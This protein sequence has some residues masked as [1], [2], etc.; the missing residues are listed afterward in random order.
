[1]S[2]ILEALKKADSERKKSGVSAHS[3]LNIAYAMPVEKKKSK[4]W[5]WLIALNMA[6]LVSIF[7]VSIYLYQLYSVNSSA[8]MRSK[9]TNN[10]TAINE[11]AI[12]S[13]V[14]EKPAINNQ[15][16]MQNQPLI[17]DDKKKQMA[18]ELSQVE[19][20]SSHP[21]RL[22]V[23]VFSKQ[24][25]KRF[26]MIKGSVLMVGDKIDGWQLINITTEGAE[27]EKYG[28]KILVHAKL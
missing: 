23:H 7:A 25:E 11:T 10:E 13:E 28:Q 3:T 17:D 8:S 26:V 24:V 21:E 1:M 20:A 4:V 14:K 9:N 5:Y 22:D 19:L 12:Q 16:T 2:Y 6:I 27:F 15:V 18:K